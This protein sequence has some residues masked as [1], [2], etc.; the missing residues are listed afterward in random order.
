MWSSAAPA[1]LPRRSLRRTILPGAELL[2]LM[3][4]LVNVEGDGFNPIRNDDLISVTSGMKYI[5]TAGGGQ[6]ET[7]TAGIDE[8]ITTESI[9]APWMKQ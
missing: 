2:K 9:K 6:L 3:E 8:N 7:P 1:P 4:W 5:V